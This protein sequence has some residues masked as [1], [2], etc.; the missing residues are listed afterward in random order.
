MLIEI[1]YYLLLVIGAYT[2]YIYK[3]NF[4]LFLIILWEWVC[5][6]VYLGF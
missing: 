3:N 5:V 2:T 4:S 1:V 6:G